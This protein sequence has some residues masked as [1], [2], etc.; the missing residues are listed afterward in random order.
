[1]LQ[2]LLRE[3]LV[4]GEIW[5]AVSDGRLDVEGKCAVLVTGRLAALKLGPGG[6][7]LGGGKVGAER[8]AWKVEEGLGR[9]RE[10]RKGDGDS[11][12]QEDEEEGS[13]CFTE[14]LA[15]RFVS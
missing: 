9:R 14:G 13:G 7:E 15:I 4:E 2:P 10:E 6:R 11:D 8:V 1:M 5:D 12:R 3:E